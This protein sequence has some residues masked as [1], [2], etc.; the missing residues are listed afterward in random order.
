MLY[1]NYKRML[2]EQPAYLK[3]CV[4]HAK[5]FLKA[6]DMNAHITHP[7]VSIR[8]YNPDAI[9]HEWKSD[10]LNIAVECLKTGWRMN[11]VD[12]DNVDNV[13][14]DIISHISDAE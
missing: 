10:N 8:V 5:T 1:D 11:G 9:I 6:I 13:V 7:S 14:N 3:G 12:Y 4:E 2:A